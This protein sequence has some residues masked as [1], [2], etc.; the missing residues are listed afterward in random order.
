MVKSNTMRRRRST[1]TTELEENPADIYDQQRRS[2]RSSAPSPA[3]SLTEHIPFQV[4]GPDWKSGSDINDIPNLD[5]SSS[6][7]GSLP[8]TAC[9]S[10][11]SLEIPAQRLSSKNWEADDEASPQIIRTTNKRKKAAKTDKDN[12]LLSA[13]KRVRYPFCR[14][15]WISVLAIL[16]LYWLL[17]LCEDSC[18]APKPRS[19]RLNYGP[20]QEVFRRV[21]DY[22]SGNTQKWYY[23]PRGWALSN[24]RPRIKVDVRDCW[25]VL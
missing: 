12:S 6:G 10:T 23:F 21:S 22:I 24:I 4:A 8:D 17:I 2:S 18:K 5:Q 19:D 25:M 1:A 13:L 20:C 3:L 16:L 14:T 9:A 7:T 15:L 11:K